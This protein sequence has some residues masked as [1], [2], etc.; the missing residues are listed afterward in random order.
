MAERSAYEFERLAVNGHVGR[1]RPWFMGDRPRVAGAGVSLHQ[2]AEVSVSFP[3]H[4]RHWAFGKSLR[5]FKRR[6]QVFCRSEDL[7]KP[8]RLLLASP[9]HPE[10]HKDKRPTHQ[11]KE[12]Q[13]EQHRFGDDSRLRNQTYDT[14]LIAPQSLFIPSPHTIVKSFTLP[15]ERGET[16]DVSGFHGLRLALV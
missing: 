13:D 6:V 4:Y 14:H 1:Y 12:Q 5:F 10:L 15:A 3:K 9:E 7:K 8:S 11:G 2:M 16:P